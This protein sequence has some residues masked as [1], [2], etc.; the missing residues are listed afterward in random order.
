VEVVIE[1]R[2]HERRSAEDR[3]RNGDSA[4]APVQVERRRV[5]SASGRR[6]ADQ[7]SVLVPG[8]G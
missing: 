8:R 1:R 6:I 5:R 2:R 3:R 4:P 7:R